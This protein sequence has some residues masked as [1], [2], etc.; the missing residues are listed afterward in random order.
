MGIHGIGPASIILIILIIAVLFGR[1]HIVNLA[2]ELGKG[3]RAF[4][5]SIDDE[6]DDKNDKPK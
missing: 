2:K 5:K 3:L 1:K 4:R 6:S